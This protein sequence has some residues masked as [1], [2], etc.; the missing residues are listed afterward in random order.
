M[1][2]W[3]EKIKLIAAAAP[4]PEYDSNG[5]PLPLTE[6]ITE[7]FANRLSVGYSEYYKADMAGYKAELKY[8]VYSFEYSG[9]Q[10]VEAGNVRYKVLRTYVH[11]ELTELTLTDMPAPQNEPAAEV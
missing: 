11:G 10:I 5:F 2:K 3:S 1:S 8:D 9:Q 6:T 7:V 4:S